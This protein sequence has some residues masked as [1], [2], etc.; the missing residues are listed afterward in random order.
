MKFLYT[1]HL[2]TSTTET[3]R[4]HE[5]LA[6]HQQTE[7]WQFQEAA[8]QVHLWVPRLIDEFK[9]DVGPIAV[10][11]DRLSRNTLGHFRPKHNGF[12]LL[13]EIAIDSGHLNQKSEV[14]QQGLTKVEAENGVVDF[15]IYWDAIGT[16]F[17]E[18]LH[19]QQEKAG[20]A[21]P[22]N[23]HNANFRQ[24]AERYGLI[25]DR[26]GV[27]TYDPDGPFIALLKKQGV[28]IPADLK[29]LQ[30][31]PTHRAKPKGT[32]SS[33]LKKWS[34]TGCEKRQNIW[35]G[36]AAV[37]V[38]CKRCKKDFVRVGVGRSEPIE[39]F[40]S[41]PAGESTIDS[42]CVPVSAASLTGTVP[43]STHDLGDG[44][45]FCSTLLPKH[46]I[47]NDTLAEGLWQLRPAERHKIKYRG[48]LV[49]TSRWEQA[50][51]K[52]YPYMGTVNL[53][54]PVPPILEPYLAWARAE[55]D[56]RLN[57]LLLCFYD[58]TH[59]YIGQHHDKTFA[60]VK[61]AQ[62]LT[63]SFGETRTFRLTREEKRADKLMVV[64][65]KDF[66]ASQGTVFLMPYGT[67]KAWK[68]GVPKS[69]QYTGRRI[70]VTFRAFKE[71]RQ[72][73]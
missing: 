5:A 53:A 44:H 60:L 49:E 22:R 68:H 40:S 23:H 29:A 34:C 21:S 71:V 4:V 17:H 33:T 57:G 59:D 39:K 38:V 47:G 11:I 28:E 54:L 27:T 63:V 8:K 37:E 26:Y 36:T 15:K 73:P 42:V 32:G 62:I 52:D 70:S 58:G 69:A 35:A 41:N 7:N 31:V 3:G 45:R 67:N 48:R 24:I 9:I 12:G 72:L 13:G 43:F 10:C 55:I 30:K 64:E 2:M 51:G 66:P 61:G 25:V 16:L 19:A 46:L 6:E 14:N 18:L 50:F 65:T 56:A 1:E 20:T